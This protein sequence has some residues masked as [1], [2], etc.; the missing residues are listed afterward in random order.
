MQ[1]QDNKNATPMMA[2]WHKCKAAAKDALLFFHLGDFYEA[3]YEDAQIIAKQLHLTLTKR[4]N[5]PMCGVPLHTSEIYIDKL[6]AKG[7]KVAIADQMEDPKKTKGLVKREIVRIIS[8]ATVVSSNLLSDKNNN[9][10]VS[11]SQIGKIFG[12]AIIDLTTAEFHVIEV[13]ENIIDE[14]YR[15]RPSEILICKKFKKDHF[16][17]LEEMQQHFSFYITEKENWYFDHEIATDTLL[18]HFSI[19]T[20]DSFGLKT[21]LA[22]ISAAG[23]A[24][25]YLSEDMQIDLSHIKTLQTQNLSSYMTLDYICMK[26]LEIF[27]TSSANKNTTL[28]S[29]LDHTATPMGARLLR[30]W[31]KHPLL[32]CKTIQQRQL[33]IEELVTKSNLLE[34]IFQ[35]LDKVRD[36]ERL[37][38]K[39]STGYA[40]PRDVIALRFSIEEVPYLQEYLLSFRSSLLQKNAANLVDLSPLAQKIKEAIVEQPPQRLADGNVFKDG[41]CSALDELRNLSKDSKSWIANYQVQ[42]RE[43]TQI[44]TLKVGFTKVFGYYIEVSKGQAHKIPSSFQRRQTLVNTERF[45]TEELKIFEQKVLTAEEKI[46]ALESELFQQL[47]KEI[48]QHEKAILDTA[49]AI[50][51]IDSLSSLA[52]VAQK[53]QYVRPVVD[54]TEVLHIV[55]GRHP[56][57]EKAL[58][59]G[60]FIPNDT[61]MDSNNNQLFIITGPNMAGKSTYI[62]QVALLCVMA[63]IGSFI[64]AQS[65]HIGVIDRIFSRIGAN[66]DLSRGQSTFMVE[67]SETANILHNA[68]SNS[69]IILDEI[70][71][72]TSTYDGLSI[73]WAV[74]E[75]L[76][77][78][79][80][81]GAKT[82]FA[83]HY[84]ELTQ[85]AD[86]FPHVVNCNVAVQETDDGIVF[87][88][89]IL[90]GGTDKSYGI[91]VAKLAGLPFAVIKR[92][93]QMLKQLEE[94][95]DKTGL[96]KMIKTTPSTEQQFHLFSFSSPD[97]QLLQMQKELQKLDVDTLTPIEALQKLFTL[98]KILNKT[99]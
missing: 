87:L 94:K 14:I 31:I 96:R 47:R 95:A 56:I 84:W 50:A 38:M 45:I 33:A 62:R 67:M 82:L 83:T 6:L 39:I 90:K 15:I 55:K 23:A 60:K 2:Q 16:S 4:A 80:N 7:F 43:K 51:H 25:K 65:A 44:K 98:K 64:P 9:F 13:E 26:N 89:K 78:T 3:F 66:D 36:I 11:I 99:S 32:C 34:K 24:I 97:P 74:A 53:H 92:A 85:L 63:Q 28:L 49:K 93:E 73:A 68:T 21:M 22:A 81:K 72:G 86:K 1:T 42:L 88:H 57:L 54:D 37:I 70:G 40:I 79:P 52:Y 71:R 48:Q 35:H 59:L 69:L 20:L 58:P 77:T 29:L 8:P 91:H 19:H 75:Y 76:L 17:L 30:N 10:F 12:L 61:H 27:D 5:I 18:S 41:Y 46:K